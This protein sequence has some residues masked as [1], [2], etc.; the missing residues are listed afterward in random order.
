MKVKIKRS[1]SIFIGVTILLGI[2]AANTGNN[3]LYI[4]VS[5]LLSLM[6]TSGLISLFNIRGIK[7]RL[8]PP[9]EVYAE[10]RTPFRLV[11]FKEGRFPSFLIKVFSEEGECLFPMV[12]LKDRECRLDMKFPRRGEVKS[13]RLVLSSDFPLGMFVRSLELEI[14]THL[15]VFPKPIPTKLPALS[16]EAK[17]E[18][19]SSRRVISKG[20]EELKNIKTYSGE[21]MKLIHWK[22]SAKV[23]DLLVK[24][25]VGEDREPVILSM[26][27]VEGSKEEKISKLAYL[28][29][30]LIKEGHAVGLK[31]DDREFPPQRGEHQKRLLLREL[32]LY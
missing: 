13:V 24:D 30:N 7:V 19:S 11:L 29:I 27:T 22:L 10:E 12:D 4:L 2:A 31:L 8:I 3:L 6:L 5:S 32:A 20:Y 28:V 1:G 9:P 18:G 25:M 26:E 16:V 23:G 14:E 17:K 15:I 21:P